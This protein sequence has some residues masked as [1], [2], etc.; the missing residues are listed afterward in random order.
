LLAGTEPINYAVALFP[1]FQALDVFGPL[2]ALNILS[3]WKGINL[4]VIARTLEPVSTRV[5]DADKFPV[6]SNFYESIVPTHTYDNPPV[7][8]D[9]LIVPG[10]RGTLDKANIDP[11]IEFVAATYPTVRYLVTVCS[12][13]SVAAR[14]GILD[15]KKATTNKM[16]F[17]SIAAERPQ[18][19]W[20]RKAR[21]VVD[22]NIWT[23]SGVSAGI[24][25]ILAFIE[26][27]YGRESAVTTARIMEYAWHDD[28][29]N[30][31]FAL[32]DKV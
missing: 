21:W 11:V 13:S 32:P 22:G 6:T 18:V 2:D 30:D 15:G 23:S 7:D 27:M 8:I 20:V 26:A 12:G 16:R 1:G 28:A 4:S 14:A 29:T 19:N 17:Q 31:P 24:D 3:R 25:T 5:P 10:G 9:I